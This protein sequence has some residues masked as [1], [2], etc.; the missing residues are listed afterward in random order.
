MASSFPLLS[1]SLSEYEVSGLEQIIYVE[2]VSPP[3]GLW[4]A[5]TT[6]DIP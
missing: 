2:P 5:A 3:R 1:L 6:S 4:T